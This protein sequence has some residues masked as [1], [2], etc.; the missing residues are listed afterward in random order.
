MIPDDNSA[1]RRSSSRPLRSILG[2]QHRGQLNAATPTR[3][4]DFFDVSYFETLT[5][6]PPTIDARRHAHQYSPRRSQPVEGPGRIVYLHSIGI[7][8]LDIEFPNR[9]SMKITSLLCQRRRI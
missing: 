5:A 4:R 8:R 7:I 6:P 9:W 1:G 2:A 3:R